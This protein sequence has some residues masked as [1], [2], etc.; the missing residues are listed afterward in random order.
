[1]SELQINPP[2]TQ[3]DFAERQTA[4]SQK[5]SDLKHEL[6]EISVKIR[7]L[8]D[9]NGEI[10]KSILSS[11]IELLDLETE[12]D[13]SRCESIISTLKTC[14]EKLHKFDIV[15]AQIS[16]IR[17]ERQKYL[18]HDAALEK[19]LNDYLTFAAQA[20]AFINML[21]LNN[22]RQSLE[23]A[24][25]KMEQRVSPLINLDEHEKSLLAEYRL[26]IQIYIARN[27][28][29]NIVKWILPVH[30]LELV[31]QDETKNGIAID[32]FNT[33]IYVETEPDWHITASYQE[34]WCG[35]FVYSIKG[36]SGGEKGLVQMTKDLIL[37]LQPRSL[38]DIHPSINI[39]V[40]EIPWNTCLIGIGRSKVRSEII[41]T[42]MQETDVIEKGIVDSS[43]LFTQRDVVSWERPLKTSTKSNWSVSGRRLRTLLM[44]LIAKGNV[45]TNGIA[46]DTLWRGLPETHLKLIKDAVPILVE[47]G[48]LTRLEIK[49]QETMQVSIN[50]SMLTEVQGLINRDITAFWEGLIR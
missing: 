31:A 3:A 50:P 14:Q 20:K 33:L 34:E 8:E 13:L 35:F 36:E 46:E 4:L 25:Q 22:Y 27:I 1:M 23:D 9:R 37:G 32:L 45:G 43:G 21:P 26:D 49:G 19:D 47:H 39:N 6:S 30:L 7:G 29:D 5:I 42:E 24:H 10:R 40:E 18:L 41:T 28:S 2:L 17:E 12:F 16:Q 15:C 38:P 48:L 44:R 11:N